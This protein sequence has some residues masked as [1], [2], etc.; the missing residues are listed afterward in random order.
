MIG[1]ASLELGWDPHNPSITLVIA[2]VHQR[3]G[4]GSATLN[5]LLRYLFGHTP[6]HVVT[7]WV[8]DWNIAGRQFLKKNGFQEA[9]R[10]RRVGIQ[11]CEY[12]DLVIHDQLRS[13][14]MQRSGGGAHGA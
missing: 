13:D 14:W 8:A 5:L 11:Q 10:M 7:A 9:G 2:P 6:A 1:H 3:Q 4:Y 12:F